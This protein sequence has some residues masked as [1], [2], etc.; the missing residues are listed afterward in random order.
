MRVAGLCAL[1]VLVLAGAVTMVAAAAA[2]VDSETVTEEVQY[3]F[4]LCMR[5]AGVGLTRAH[6]Q[7]LQSINKIVSSTTVVKALQHETDIQD[8]EIAD[9]EQHLEKELSGTHRPPLGAA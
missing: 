8:K 2:E 5:R 7:E 1:A 3:C 9:M 4:V 6:V